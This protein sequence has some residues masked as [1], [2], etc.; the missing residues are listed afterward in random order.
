MAHTFVC[1]PARNILS[2]IMETNGSRVQREINLIRLIYR[3]SRV[4]WLC[5]SHQR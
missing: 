5:D 4:W 2:I 1:I 3:L